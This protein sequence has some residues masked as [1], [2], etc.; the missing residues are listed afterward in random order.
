MKEYG[1]GRGTMN[2]TIEEMKRIGYNRE[3]KRGMGETN[4][5]KTERLKAA[6]QG[7]SQS[8]L[9]QLLSCAASELYV[10]SLIL[11]LLCTVSMLNF[12]PSIL[13]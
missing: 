10:F 12:T 8:L 7:S 5:Y 11:L 3:E 2:R 1:S 4:E 6:T 9:L 13:I